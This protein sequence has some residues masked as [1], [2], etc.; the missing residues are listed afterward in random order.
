MSKSYCFT[1]NNYTEQ[2][3]ET[4]KAVNTS[5]LVYG[6]EVGEM[7]T[8]H[9]QGYLEFS[10]KKRFTTVKKL[11]GNRYHIEP[12]RGTQEQAITYCKKDGDVHEQGTPYIQGARADLDQARND[13]ADN[14][15]RSVTSWGNLQQIKVAEKYLTYNEISRD[16]ETKVIWLWGLT[17]SGKSRLARE[18]SNMDDCYIK[19]EGS[20]WWDGYDGHEYIIIDDFRSSWWPLTYMLRLLDRY[21]CLVEVKGGMRQILAKTIIITSLWPPNLTY[22]G[23]G[24]DIKQLER[25][26]SEVRGVVLPPDFEPRLE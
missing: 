13:A 7:K 20:K 12:R 1:L 3:I 5:Y 21:A 17:G 23:C 25:R 10:T 16:W 6:K 11:L 2:E 24:E 26:V 15:M 9:L 19:S 14:G 8:P 18:L 4:L 22:M